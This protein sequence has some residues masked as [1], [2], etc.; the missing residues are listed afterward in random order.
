[1]TP[2]KKTTH[3]RAKSSSKRTPKKAPASEPQMIA[4][5]VILGIL[6]IG[7][8]FYTGYLVGKSGGEGPAVDGSQTGSA[9]VDKLTI[10]D[11][12]WLFAQA[13]RRMHFGDSVVE[14]MEHPPGGD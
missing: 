9:G 8:S 2:K 11:G 3:K 7:T 6:V 13:I 10:V 4:V 5:Y 14:L 12:S 1:M